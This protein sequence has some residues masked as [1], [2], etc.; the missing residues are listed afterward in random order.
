MTQA[1]DIAIHA[2]KHRQRHGR[3]TTE[4]K[5]AT[6]HTNIQTNE[7][8]HAYPWKDKAC[9]SKAK[10]KNTQTQWTKRRMN[11]PECFQIQLFASMHDAFRRT[12][13]E[14]TKTLNAIL[15]STLGIRC[16]VSSRMSF[17][18]VHTLSCPHTYK[19]HTFRVCL[20]H[21]DVC[22]HA[23]SM[24]LMCV[25]HIAVFA[26]TQSPCVCYVSHT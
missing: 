16:H 8:T 15:G 24:Y 19:V 2:W 14:L 11:V 20:T 3:M 12:Y 18:C 22:M 5:Q 25:T 1:T 21:C 10:H 26:C 7:N 23:K 13:S 6:T 4:C 17:G 9:S